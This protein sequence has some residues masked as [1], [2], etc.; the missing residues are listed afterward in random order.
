MGRL[1]ERRLEREFKSALRN[2]APLG[3]T[4]KTEFSIYPYTLLSL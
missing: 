2:N 4:S 3:W 1:V